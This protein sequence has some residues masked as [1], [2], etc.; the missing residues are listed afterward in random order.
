MQQSVVCRRCRSSSVVTYTLQDGLLNTRKLCE[1]CRYERGSL[2]HHHDHPHRRHDSF[3][4]RAEATTR[5]ERRWY[6]NRKFETRF[7][8]VNPWLTLVFLMK[9]DRLL[10][11]LCRFT[12]S[13]ISNRDKSPTG[14]QDCHYHPIAPRSGRCTG[15]IGENGAPWH[16]CW[17][18]LNT[19]LFLE[20]PWSLQLNILARLNS[21]GDSVAR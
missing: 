17:L 18:P 9:K 10:T 16:P 11:E 7:N 12:A 1:S 4:Q 15:D 13:P 20:L 3:T 19:S 21:L 14:P 6:R 5:F 8:P 2:N